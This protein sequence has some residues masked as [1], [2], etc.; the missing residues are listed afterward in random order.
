M[1]SSFHD[2]LPLRSRTTPRM[3]RTAASN[4]GPKVQTPM[5]PLIE[6]II[7]PIMFPIIEGIIHIVRT[8][9]T[10]MAPAMISTMIISDAQQRAIRRTQ[11]FVFIHQLESCVE[12]V[13]VEKV[14]G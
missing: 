4:N 8:H 9:K 1:I 3:T 6:P 5:H 11:Q 14:D 7:P 2:Q 12:I 13:L 10:R